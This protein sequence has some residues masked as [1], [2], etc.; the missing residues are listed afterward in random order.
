[1]FHRI[2]SLRPCAHDLNIGGQAVP[3]SVPSS[4][5]RSRAMFAGAQLGIPVVV[6]AVVRLGAAGNPMILGP[7]TLS[8]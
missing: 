7:D 5:K 4:G 8:S 2:Y 1:M 3:I 6:A